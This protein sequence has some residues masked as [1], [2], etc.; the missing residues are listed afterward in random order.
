MNLTDLIGA[1][2]G[3]GFSSFTEP[4]AAIEEH[5]PFGS[6]P[7]RERDFYEKIKIVIGDDNEQIN[8]QSHRYE[9]HKMRL[10][11]ELEDEILFD[12]LS[13][14]ERG[15]KLYERENYCHTNKLCTKCYEKLEDGVCPYCS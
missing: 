13:E 5:D 3:S 14:Y 10:V 2:F 15:V 1:L 11:F 4:H 9:A 12:G 6:L 7:K 8:P